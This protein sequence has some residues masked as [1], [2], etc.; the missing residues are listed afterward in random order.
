[1]IKRI[2][3]I[4]GIITLLVCMGYASN[5]DIPKETAKQDTYYEPEYHVFVINGEIYEGSYIDGE[6]A[7]ALEQYAGRIPDEFLEN[8]DD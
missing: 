3:K 1:M 2:I 8:P 6:W 7:E 4:L 5:W